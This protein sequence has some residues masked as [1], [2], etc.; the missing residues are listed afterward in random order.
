MVDAEKDALAV[1]V[2]VESARVTKRAFECDGISGMSRGAD[3]PRLPRVKHGVRP[4]LSHI[5]RQRTLALYRVNPI[6]IADIRLLVA[7]VCPR[8]TMKSVSKGMR[9]QR[10]VSQWL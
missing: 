9:A 8:H 5:S 4:F 6:Y 7:V 1:S 3:K 2:M 10:N